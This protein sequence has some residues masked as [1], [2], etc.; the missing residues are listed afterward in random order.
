MYLAEY[1]AA[2]CN[3]YRH[4]IELSF[5]NMYIT[6]RTAISSRMNTS[7][8]GRYWERQTLLTPDIRSYGLNDLTS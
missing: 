8:G 2:L 3:I 4:G 6:N 5:Y 7:P 1:I